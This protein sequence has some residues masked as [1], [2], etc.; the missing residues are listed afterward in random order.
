LTPIAYKPK[1]RRALRALVLIGLVACGNS[2]GAPPCAAVG[3]K[4]VVL[5]QADLD[6]A[7]LDE[8][9]RRLVLDQLPAMRDTLVNVCTETKWEPSVRT[10]MVDATDHA[11]FEACE[12]ALN[13]TQREA[14]ERGLP[15]ER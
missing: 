13:S 12:G 7:T 1:T 3:A 8:T 14:L 10:C 5:A 6:K 4:L 15:D 9:T 11:G 2:K